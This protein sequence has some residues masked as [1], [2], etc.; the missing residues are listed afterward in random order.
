MSDSRCLILISQRPEDVKFFQMM[1]RLLK[2]PFLQVQSANEI[3][4]GLLKHGDSLVIWDMDHAGTMQDGH[5]LS[6]KTVQGALGDGVDPARVFVVTDKTANQYPELFA[7]AGVSHRLFQHNI[8]R[9]Y[10]VPGFMILSRVMLKGFSPQ[11]RGLSEYFPEG[12]K[13]QKLSLKKAEHRRPAADAMQNFMTKLNVDERIAA[14]AAQATDEFLMNAIFDAATDR[15]GMRTRNLL[16]RK[17]KFDF[18]PREQVEVE[19]AAT[20]DY[21]GLCVTDHFGSLSLEAVMKSLGQHYHKQDYKPRKTGPGAGLGIYG[22]YESG[23]S[24]MLACEPRK[25]TDAL[26]FFP[27]AKSFKAFKAGFRFSACFVASGK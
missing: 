18:G 17:A 15:D 9:H 19:A 23:L 7:E 12:T 3:F 22:V 26:I 20:K 1:S 11:P 8:L 6:F 16:D 10:D 13:I 5:P 27:R 14:K 4:E 21:I 2:L 25:R 24:L